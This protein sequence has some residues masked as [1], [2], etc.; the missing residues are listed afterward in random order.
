[1]TAASMA[2]SCGIWVLTLDMPVALKDRASTELDRSKK[3]DEEHSARI[4]CSGRLP[5]SDSM[6]ATRTT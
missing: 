4:A 2:D 5:S 6:A 3:A 1:M